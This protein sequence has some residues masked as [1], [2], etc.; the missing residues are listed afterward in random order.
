MA[1]KINIQ[2]LEDN[3]LCTI[4]GNFFTEYEA[5]RAL[6]KAGIESPSGA[7]LE[8]FFLE[9]D[10]SDENMLYLPSQRLS[11]LFDA[12]DDTY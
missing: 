6:Q 5:M 1:R 3:F 8:E 12:Y 2:H 11:E 10:A 9:M 7:D 4:T